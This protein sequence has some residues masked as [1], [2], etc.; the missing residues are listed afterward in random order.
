MAYIPKKR[1]TWEEYVPPVPLKLLEAMEPTEIA[2]FL[3]KWQSKTVFDLCPVTAKF[4]NRAPQ[5]LRGQ[6]GR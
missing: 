2:D 4:P 5:L 1:G 6:G 3:D